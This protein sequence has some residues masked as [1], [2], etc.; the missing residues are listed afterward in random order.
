[1]KD[2]GPTPDESIQVWSALHPGV[3]IALVV[4]GPLIILAG[5]LYGIFAK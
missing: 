2:E 3:R 4:V 1:M 5:I